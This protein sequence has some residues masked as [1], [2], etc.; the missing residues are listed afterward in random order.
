MMVLL[1]DQYMNKVTS[2]IVSK[3]KEEKRK[4]SVRNDFSDDSITCTCKKFEFAGIQCCHVLK[5]LDIK[6]VKELPQIYYL[7]R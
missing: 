7:K 6:N 3:G 4:H 1:M 5:V 2:K